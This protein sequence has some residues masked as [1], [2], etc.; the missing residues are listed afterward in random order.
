MKKYLGI[1]F[2]LVA[3]IFGSELVLAETSATPPPA[4]DTGSGIGP[5]QNF[6]QSGSD[7]QRDGANFQ[8]DGSNFQKDAPNFQRDGSNFQ[9]D[10][11]DFQK[12]GANFERDGSN[13][14]QPNNQPKDS[15]RMAPPV[16]QRPP[17]RDNQDQQQERQNK[18]GQAMAER[19]ATQLKNS[20]KSLTKAQ[21]KLQKSGLNLPSD[22]KENISDANSLISSLA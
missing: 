5:Q 4:G 20:L 12:D 19:M 6:Q 22:C 18:Q 13:F 8:R 14:T 16:N 11:K 7:F 3:L 15:D 21:V 10:G 9:K 2:L 17:N 1:V